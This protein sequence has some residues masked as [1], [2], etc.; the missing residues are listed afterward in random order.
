MEADVC[1]HFEHS[2]R[3]NTYARTRLERGRPCQGRTVE[4]KPYR[5]IRTG[6]CDRCD[7]HWRHKSGG[8]DGRHGR[9]RL[10]LRRWRGRLPLLQLQ[11]LHPLLS[12]RLQP[13]NLYRLCRG[14]LEVSWRSS[15]IMLSFM[16]S[17]QSFARLWS[18]T[19]AGRKESPFS[20]LP[21]SLL[22][23]FLCKSTRER[24]CE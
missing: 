11:L 19:Q 10:R 2:C 18:S 9:R 1:L 17:D 16:P 7:R 14:E 4:H 5:R 22:L 6:S 24:R 13:Q 21:S 23:S 8:G 20:M 3:R 12:P 15:G